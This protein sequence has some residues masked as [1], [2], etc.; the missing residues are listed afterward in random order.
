MALAV[1][2]YAAPAVVTWLGLRLESEK[3]HAIYILGQKCGREQAL[4]R[5]SILHLLTGD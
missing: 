1:A 3:Q 4:C 5:I 2:I